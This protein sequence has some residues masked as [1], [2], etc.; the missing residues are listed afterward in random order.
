[1]RQLPSGKAAA[2]EREYPFIVELAV[3]AKGL[4][5][6]L[7]RRLL[8]FHKTRHIQPRHGRSTKTYYR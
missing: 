6:G 8:D 2:N 5:V 3:A 4:E 7:S 1:M